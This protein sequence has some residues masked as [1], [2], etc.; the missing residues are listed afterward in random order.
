MADYASLIHLRYRTS[1]MIDKFRIGFEKEDFQKMTPEERGLFL[2]LGYSSNQ[3]N[4][5]WK[6]VIEATNR[7]PG[8]PVDSRVSGAQTQIIARLLI[9]ALW[10]AWRLVE[11]HLLKSKLGKDVVPLLDEPASKA[12]G[13][14]KKRFGTSG[15]IAAVRND[16]AFHYPDGQ[17]IE[18]AFQK[19][20]ASEEGP[21]DWSLYMS[22]ALLNCFFFA[23]D[24]VFVV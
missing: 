24:F 1:E 21:E 10:E 7:T 11:S 17:Q 19:A 14:L 2:L 15:M 8:D 3:V 22:Q 20:A 18:A 5:L 16:Y 4:V 13:Q 23:S 6:L 12:L 9:G